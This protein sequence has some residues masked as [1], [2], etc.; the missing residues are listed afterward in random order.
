MKVLTIGSD[1][2]LFEKDSAVR[3]RTIEYGSLC[4]ELH[5]IVFTKKGFCQ[6]KFGNVF[7]CPTNSSNRLAYICDAV[8]V[9]QKIIGKDWLISAQDPFEAGL[10]G[11]FLKK[12]SGAKLQLQIHT[13]FLNKYFW[14]ASFLNKVR[15]IMAKCLLGEADGL[16]VVSERIKNLLA[17]FKLK[18]KISVLPIFVDVA[19]L[20]ISPVKESL[21]QKYP[22]FDFITLMI[23]R[24]EKE[25]NVVLA[26]KSLAKLVLKNPKSGLVIVGE[27]SEKESLRCLAKKLKLEKNLAFE[28]WRDDLTSF[29]K[30]ADLYLLTSN[31]EGYGRTVVEA[32]AAGCPVLMSDVGVAGELIKNNETGRVFPVNNQK[33][34][35][36]TWEELIKD[37]E[38]RKRLAE[39]ALEILRSFPEKSQYLNLYKKSWQD[40]L[41]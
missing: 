36:R 24:L 17:S 1:R 40:C 12:F 2:K 33:E 34:L 39:K 30:S 35:L 6:E 8:R 10:S 7:L 15:V 27:G 20:Q 31:Y 11:Y 37:D 26:L 29:Y 19:G 25:K 13:D 4:E 18:A 23:S 21:K 9:G 14:R 32:M 22:Q 5:I 28:S 38:Q 3:S 16:R 41:E